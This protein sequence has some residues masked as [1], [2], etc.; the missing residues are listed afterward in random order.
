MCVPVHVCIHVRVFVLYH[1]AT[2]GKLLAVMVYTGPHVPT[3]SQL[4]VCVCVY[5]YKYVCCYII[6]LYNNK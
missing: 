4:C 2:K 5:I 6:E 1:L 3:A